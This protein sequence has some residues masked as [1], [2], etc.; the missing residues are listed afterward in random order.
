VAFGLTKNKLKVVGDTQ[1]DSLLKDV[2]VAVKE[3]FR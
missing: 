2:Q 1:R 3:G